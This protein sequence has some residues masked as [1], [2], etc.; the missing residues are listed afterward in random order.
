MRKRHALQMVFVMVLICAGWTA[1]VLAQGFDVK[2]QYYTV[3]DFK[4]SSGQVL[5][6]M[7]IEYG[8]LG[9]PQKDAAGNIVNAVVWC[10]GWSGN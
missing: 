10:H 3:K 9:T 1:Q 4:L 8:T 7:K 5:P 6:E 2:P